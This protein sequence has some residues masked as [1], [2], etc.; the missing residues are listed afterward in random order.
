M[1]PS[2][3]LA[4]CVCCVLRSTMNTMPQCLKL[5]CMHGTEGT[6]LSTASFSVGDRG[7]GMLIDL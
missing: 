6:Y 2:A 7:C 4:M 3:M 5:R 1:Q